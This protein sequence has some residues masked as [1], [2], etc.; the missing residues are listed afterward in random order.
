MCLAPASFRHAGLKVQ[1]RTGT[2]HVARHG[3]GQLVTNESKHKLSY[4]RKYAATVSMQPLP[5]GVILTQ[6][7]GS[8][9]CELGHMCSL[10]LQEPFSSELEK[11]L[12]NVDR[13]NHSRELHLSEDKPDY[14][15]AARCSQA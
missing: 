5:S 13:S 2:Q 1:G 15:K 14:I 7:A 4:D 10:Q 12:G 8:A 6:R 9:A 3:K 11:F